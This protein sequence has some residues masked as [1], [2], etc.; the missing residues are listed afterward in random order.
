MLIFGSISYLNLLPFQIF[1]KKY[2]KSTQVKQIIAYKKGVPSQINI[3]FKKNRIDA[4]FISSIK[5]KNEKCLNLGIAAKGAVYSVLAIQGKRAPDIES[6]TSN[7]L[8]EILNIGGEIII[9]DKAL[10]YY[11]KNSNSRDFKDLSLEWFKKTSLPF[12]FARLCYKKNGK[13]IRKLAANF[14]KTEYKIP[15]YYLKKAAKNKNITPAELKWYLKQ[16]NYKLNHK[17]LKSLKLFF[18][19]RFRWQRQRF[20]S[21]A[22]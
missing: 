21:H 6:D 15:Q 18:K 19:K 1:M 2:I 4:A 10:K 13:L 16:I 5:S 14:I 20:L 8:A 3:D 12:V 11:L 22:L 17:E 9:G 7:A